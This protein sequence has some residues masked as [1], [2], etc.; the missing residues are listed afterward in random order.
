MMARIT[1]ERLG[2]IRLHPDEADACAATGDWHLRA[3]ILNVATYSRDHVSG[4]GK[5]ADS[6][7][8]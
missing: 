3:D 8:M 2:A 6:S 4:L 5:A 7:S 1:A